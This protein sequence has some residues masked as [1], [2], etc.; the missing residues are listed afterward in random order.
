MPPRAI[1]RATARVPRHPYRAWAG[2]ASQSKGSGY[3]RPDLPCCILARGASPPPGGKGAGCEA[4]HR[5]LTPPSPRLPLSWGRGANQSW[6][7]EQT[8]LSTRWRRDGG[9]DAVSLPPCGCSDRSQGRG[10]SPFTTLAAT[11]PREGRK[12]RPACCAGAGVKF[13]PR[14]GSSITGCWA[15]DF[16]SRGNPPRRFGGLQ[17]LM[18]RTS[19]PRLPPSA[20]QMNAVRAAPLGA[21][22]VA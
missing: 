22:C 18:P 6:R 3:A 9:E 2:R 15:M 13:H 7:R 1:H 21:E 8:P 20:H 11:L 19:S 5:D 16:S 17:K 4:L 14:L 10:N 12:A